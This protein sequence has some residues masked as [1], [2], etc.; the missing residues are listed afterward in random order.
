LLLRPGSFAGFS[1]GKEV[2][3]A[4]TTHSFDHVKTFLNR[5]FP[6]VTLFFWTSFVFFFVLKLHSHWWFE[7]DTI[8]YSFARGFRSPLDFFMSREALGAPS[9]G[10]QP[11]P[12]MNVLYWIDMKL[13]GVNPAGAY[14]H[15]FLAYLAT[16]L[17]IF[18]L[19]RQFTSKGRALVISLLWSISTTVV[20]LIEF[21]ST[22]HYLYGIF[23]SCISLALVLKARAATATKDRTAYFY[24]A[25]ILMLCSFF[26]KQ[27]FV[28]FLATLYAT[29]FFKSSFKNGRIP[30]VLSLGAYAAW[31]VVV[32][33]IKNQYQ[34]ILVSEIS[35]LTAFLKY[36][37]EAPFGPGAPAF[38]STALL[39]GTMTYLLFSQRDF[40]FSSIVFT[41]VATYSA[42]TV[43][44]FL[45]IV[46]VSGALAAAGHEPGTWYRAFALWS[47]FLLIGPLI[48]LAKR[49]NCM[50]FGVIACSCFLIACIQLKSTSEYWFGLKERYRIA[51][52]AALSNPATE[53]RS[54]LPAWW[55]WPG[56]EQLYG[57]KLKIIR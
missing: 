50:L 25:F 2:L 19:C 13:W 56:L 41:H 11:I 18:F 22:R 38:V 27:I 48:V 5:C 53:I 42:I 6:E 37:L 21:L 26:C 40:R 10:I 23:F 46:P 12:L 7:D 57:V 3:V 1:I 45:R 34:P 39:V 30:F 44:A 20:V 14:F 29:M 43:A 35:Q 55:F 52:Q 24:L 54:S 31:T 32:H 36:S 49:A 9:M 17:A 33:G 47:T 51:G 8:N 4:P 16:T 15:S 28:L